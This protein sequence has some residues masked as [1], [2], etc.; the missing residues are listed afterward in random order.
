[1]NAISFT[2]WFRKSSFAFVS[3]EQYLYFVGYSRQAWLKWGNNRHRFWTR[4]GRN[5]IRASMFEAISLTRLGAFYI[6]SCSASR[7]EIETFV[8]CF[9]KSNASFSMEGRLFLKKCFDLCVYCCAAYPI[10]ITKCIT[11]YI[12]FNWKLIDRYDVLQN[13]IRMLSVLQSPSTRP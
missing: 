9:R 3:R 5:V 8:E 10:R 11:Q 12:K 2:T 13:P 4:I 1:M 7:N 6:A